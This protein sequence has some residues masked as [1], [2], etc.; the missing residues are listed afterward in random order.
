MN[1][2]YRRYFSSNKQCFDLFLDSKIIPIT[3]YLQQIDVFQS[4]TAQNASLLASLFRWRKLKRGETLFEEGSPGAEF[5]V[6]AKGTVAVVVYVRE[7]E[8]YQMNA[9]NDDQHHTSQEFI[10]GGAKISM[11]D[12]GNRQ[13]TSSM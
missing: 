13:C 11:A 6:V 7:V 2:I 1:G 8:N 9:A 4:I 12:P 3:S 10:V 5:Y